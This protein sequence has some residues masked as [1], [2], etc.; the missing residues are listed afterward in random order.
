[1]RDQIDQ[2]PTD[3]TGLHFPVLH[4]QSRIFQYCIFDPS[5]LT[6]L[7]PHFPILHFPVP[8]F[9]R[10]RL[11]VQNFLDKDLQGRLS[12][13]HG[14]PTGLAIYSISDHQVHNT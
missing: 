5:N 7:V 2:R 14:A 9:Q 8:Y 4:L 10:P 12:S 1:V 13:M 6:S 11:F 3:T